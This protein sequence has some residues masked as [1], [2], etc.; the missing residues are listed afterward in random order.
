VPFDRS[1]DSLKPQSRQRLTSPTWLLCVAAVLTLV[2]LLVPAG[3]SATVSFGPQSDFGAGAHP[4]S[5]AIGDLN[6]DG[7]TDLVVVNYESS[8]VSVLL[9]TG[10]G[11]F[12]AP[13][14]L[15]VGAYPYSV[16]IG[17]LDGDGHP[18]LAV[19]NAGSNTVSVLLGTGNGS[20]GAPSSFAVGQDPTSVAIADLDG[21]GHPDLAVANYGSNTVSV[22]LGTGN[23][24]FGAAS[25]LAIGAYPYPVGPF[26]VAIG[27]LDG[28]GHPDLAVA[29]LESNTV[30]VLLG[31]GNGS[32]DAPSS[33]AVG[34]GSSSV[35]IGDLNGDGHPDL[36]VANE[37]SNTVSVL[38]GTGNGSFGAASSLAVGAEPVSVAIGDLD[39]DGY[40]DLATANFGSNSVSVLPGTGN[41]SFGAASSLAVGA[42]P[43][44]VAIGDLDGDGH[45][46]LAVANGGFNTVSVLL[47]TVTKA[48]PTISSEASG[49]VTLG[50]QVTDTAT[51]SGGQSPG[52]TITFKA[53]GPDDATCSA[54]PAYTSS[55]VAV[56]GDGAYTSPAFTPSAAGTY[57]FVAGY[58]G[59]AGNETAA[60]ACNDADESVAVGKAATM[61]SL[62]ATPDPAELGNTVT[63]TAKVAGAGP[64]G[65]VTFSDGTAVL[66]TAT[67]GADGTA[68][69]TVTS[70][71][72]GPH[73]LSAAYSGDADHLP[74]TSSPLGEAISAPAASPFTPTPLVP[75]VKISYNP[76]HP[77]ARNSANGPRYTFRFAGQAAGTTFYCR[78]DKAPFELCHSPMVY[79]HLRRG[80][81]VF[82]VKSVDASGVESATQTVHFVAGRRRR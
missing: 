34:A 13:S 81:H 10:T 11:S 67:L 50:G 77:H 12:G 18:D 36:A 48:T 9:G 16:A 19:A 40:P 72:A 38:L 32:F 30:S 23:G 8:S 4:Y 17:D 3:A 80:R 56:S 6:G 54:A 82:A 41:G 57:R 47:A 59:D 33:F 51:I 37:S 7:N 74:S 76:N 79:R 71:A 60:G 52:G 20:F 24:S 27:D 45:P 78:I 63:L 43:H 25:S 15:A 55:A 53:Y 65:T 22:L 39:G 21:D 58:S 14:S 49:P 5:V 62:A 29:N 35:A 2:G 31:T 68:G 75:E 28:D 46:D 61:T 69:L 64:T 26:S 70:L 66:G 44:S 73:Q 1:E 42:N